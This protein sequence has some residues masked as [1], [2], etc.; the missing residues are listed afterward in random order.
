MKTMVTKDTFCQD[1]VSDFDHQNLTIALSL[2]SSFTNGSIFL[3]ENVNAMSSFF[4]LLTIC[5]CEK[6]CEKKK[7]SSSYNEF[8][9]SVAN[10]LSSNQN[11]KF[12]SSLVQNILQT[13]IILLVIF[14]DLSNL[15]RVNEIFYFTF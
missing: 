12:C 4:F 6:L 5:R 1:V 8:L 13:V 14:M 3:L 11:N 15:H 9:L 7:K 2:V 10:E